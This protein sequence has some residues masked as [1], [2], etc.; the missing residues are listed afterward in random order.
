MSIYR[1]HGFTLVELL[2]VIAIIGILVAL[3][4]PAV[5]AAREAARRGQCTNNLK[6]LS[7]AFQNYHDTYGVFPAFN[8]PVAG[9]ANW[10]SHGALTMILPFIEQEP[11]YDQIDFTTGW[12]SGANASVRY[13]QIDGFRCP[14]TRDYPNNQFAPSNYAVSAGS[15]VNIYSAGSPVPASGIFHRS[16]CRRMGSVLDGLSNTIMISEFLCGDGDNGIFDRRRDHAENLNTGL[17]ADQFPSAAEIEAAGAAC[18]STGPGAHGSQGGRDWFASFPAQNV[19]NTIV[20]PNWHHVSCCV[21]GIGGYAC[22]NSGIFAARSEHP[23][24]AM[25]AR[26]DGSTTFV[27]ETIELK[28]WQYVGAAADGNSVEVP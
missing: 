13:T 14:S 27:S 1:R 6:Q 4:L 10:N 22:H 3:L 21:G 11:L 2:V 12:D 25:A 20:P 23:G 18:D 8:F 9:T 7:L 24:G 5:Q 28:T 17:L 26:G 19:F 15:R 16:R